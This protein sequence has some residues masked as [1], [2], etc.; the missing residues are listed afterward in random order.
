M[1]ISLRDRPFNPYEEL[2][3]LQDR[4][5][6]RSGKYGA[7]CSFVG[8]MRDF[9]DGETVSR[10][11]LEYYPGMTEKHLQK[12]IEDARHR[13]SLT[14]VLIIHRTGEIFPNDPIVLVAVW[15]THRGLAFDACRYI[16]EELKAKA[17]FWKKETTPNGERWV[18]K[19]TGGY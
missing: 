6:L 15:A 16:T 19:N 9:N 18:D 14:D 12:I 11:V 8:V 5:L 3:Q 1:A 2:I 13:W 4:V 7:T 10:M 17:P